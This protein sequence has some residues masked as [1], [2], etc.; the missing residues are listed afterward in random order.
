MEALAR[1]PFQGVINIIRFNWHF[2]AIAFALI[3][4]L[5]VGTIFLEETM[6][7]IIPVVIVTTVASIALSLGVS[8][9]VYDYSNIYSL[10]WLQAIN[11]PHEASLVNIHAGFDE[12][13]HLLAQRYPECTLQVFD[14]YD[15]E[16]HTEVSIERAR[17]LYMSYP[18]TK[19]VDTAH[20]PLTENSEDYIFNIFAAH[21]IRNT[22]ERVSFLK[23]LH[24][25]IKPTGR[26]VIVEHLRDVPNFIA[27]NIGFFHFHSR[28]EW[29]RNFTDAGF[30]VEL[31]RS[32]T[33]F[34]AL[35]ILRK[36][37]DTTH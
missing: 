1:K 8:Y 7:W 15:P 14:F 6:Q 35:F 20:I 13:S 5:A 25:G 12:T 23:Q 3:F 17:K 10:D 11:V 36:N 33:P 27:Y 16:K 31:E 30:T 24:A 4:I 9:Y 18:Q 2:Y 34:V 21:E 37:D 28:A 26:V 32:L 22:T 19:K 29:K